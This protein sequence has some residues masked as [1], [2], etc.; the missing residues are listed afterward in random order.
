MEAIAHYNRYIAHHTKWS[1]VSSVTVDYN[2]LQQSE[3]QLS[4]GA[5]HNGNKCYVGYTPSGPV[6]AKSAAFVI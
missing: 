2:R 5:Q 4:Q 3:L 6:L 1:T